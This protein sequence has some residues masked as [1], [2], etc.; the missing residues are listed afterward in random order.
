MA[1]GELVWA[2]TAMV[3]VP[4]TNFFEF[5]VKKNW[6]SNEILTKKQ[7]FY[8]D[9]TTFGQKNKKS[10][11]ENPFPNLKSG[12]ENPFQILKSSAENP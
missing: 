8:E 10:S 12:S 5:R 9:Y 11:S 4:K 6:F 2:K 1:S 3:P 7:D